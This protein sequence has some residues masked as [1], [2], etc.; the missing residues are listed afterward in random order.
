MCPHEE[1]PQ[2]DVQGH[3]SSYEQDLSDDNKQRKKND[4][5]TKRK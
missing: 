3:C 2:D 5:S 1:I 4:L